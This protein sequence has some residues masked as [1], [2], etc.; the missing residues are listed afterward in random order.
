MAKALTR[1]A[2]NI[3]YATVMGSKSV[4]LY[5]HCE[6]FACVVEVNSIPMYSYIGRYVY[7]VFLYSYH[8]LY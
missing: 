2:M 6:V 8:H 3:N 7:Y 4:F 5:F 1:R